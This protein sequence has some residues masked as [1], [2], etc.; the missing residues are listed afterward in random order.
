MIE[1]KSKYDIPSARIDPG[2]LT[3][4]ADVA[5]GLTITVR[6]LRAQNDGDS[7]GIGIEL[8]DRSRNLS[9]SRRYT[10]HTLL[11]S[12]LKLRR[13]AI[14]QQK[15]IEIE[16]AA[17]LSAAWQRGLSIL[18]YGA[19]SAQALTLKLR[20][21]GFDADVAARAVELIRSQ[22]YLQEDND[23]CREAERSLLKGWGLRRI[24]QYLRQRGYGADSIRVAMEALGEEDF[25]QHCCRI[26]RK[27]HPAL[28]EDAKQKQKIIAYLLRYGYDMSEIR[29][30]LA[31]AWA[32]DEDE[33]Q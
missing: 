12:E 29:H 28:P 22:G 30:A 13:G 18:A 21:R 2:T 14:T 10:V 17:T 16:Q 3:L 8:S 26:A 20:Q 25:E 27:Y 9:E 31:Y 24:E 15:L 33:L 11:F 19:N 6:Y 32:D 7:I 4:G 1:I 5:D 23:A